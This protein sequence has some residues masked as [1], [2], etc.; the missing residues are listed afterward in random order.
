M[1]MTVRPSLRRLAAGL[2]GATL[3]LVCIVAT[4]LHF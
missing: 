3:A 1:M 2:A 4:S